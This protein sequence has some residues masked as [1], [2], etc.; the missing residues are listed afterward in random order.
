MIRAL[1][2]ER[3]HPGSFRYKDWGAMA[4]IGRSRAVATFGRLSLKGSVAW[5]AWSLVHLILLID[6]RSRL[7][8]YLNWT[9]AWFTRGAE[10]D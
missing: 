10:Q 5:W 3:R 9:W 6:F 1:I 2:G 4:V 8:V 7:S